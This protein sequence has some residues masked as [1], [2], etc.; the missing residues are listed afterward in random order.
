[1]RFNKTASTNT[2]TFNTDATIGSAGTFT[3][4]IAI[5]SA[6]SLVNFANGATATGMTDASY[7]DGPV[8]KT[9]TNAF[10]FP[11]GA[12]NFYRPIGISAPGAATDHFTAQYFKSG[13]TF[14]G[15]PT[16]PSGLWTVSGCEYWILNRTNGASNVSVTLSWNRAACSGIYVNNPATLRVTRWTGTAWVNHGNGGTAG[17]VSD[18]TIVS[19]G[20]VNSFSPFTLASTTPESPLP[21]VLEKFWAENTPAAVTLKWNTVSELNSDFFTLQRSSNGFDFETVY[22]IKGAGT[23]LEKH[24]YNHTDDGPLAGLSYYKLL[25]TD[26]DGNVT[27]W[28]LSVKREGED[29]P[30]TVSPNPAGNEVVTFGKKVSIVVINSLGVEA[31]Q[32][33]EVLSLDVSHLSAG[34]YLIRNQKGQITRLVKN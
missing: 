5:T 34:V 23:S 9:G 32:Y 19:A 4:G 25:Q 3:T 18:G 17:T 16:W 21:V 15:S 27:S 1:V 29:L 11:V 22:T 33:E 12:G 7:V 26:Y 8:R 24:Y 6:T 20:T 13:Q 31:G 28:M 14:G 10:T 30:F 2:I